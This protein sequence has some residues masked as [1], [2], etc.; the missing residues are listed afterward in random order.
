[1]SSHSNP[2]CPLRRQPPPDGCALAHRELRVGR[3]RSTSSTILCCTY[4]RTNHDNIHV[5]G[6]KKEGTTNTRFDTVMVTGLDRFRLVVD[7]ID[8]VDQLKAVGVGIRQEWETSGHGRA[9]TRARTVTT[10]LRYASGSGRTEAGSAHVRK[11]SP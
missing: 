10:C 7:A 2:E 4:R 8:R 6:C 5:R 9:C 1:M 3:G 11:A